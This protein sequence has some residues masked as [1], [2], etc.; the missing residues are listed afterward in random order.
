QRLV[1]PEQS[2]VRGLNDDPVRGEPELVLGDYAL[3]GGLE[4]ELAGDL[5]VLVGDDVVHAGWR[6]VLDR[7]ADETAVGGDVRR[8]VAGRRRPRARRGRVEAPDVLERAVPE[9]HQP[10]PLR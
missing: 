7:T 6:T 5:D 9:L 4:L 1:D 10:D 2:P 8:Q 3:D